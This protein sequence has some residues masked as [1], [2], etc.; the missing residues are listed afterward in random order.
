MGSS[1]RLSLRF[2]RFHRFC[3]ASRPNDVDDNCRK[4]ELEQSEARRSADVGMGRITLQCAPPVASAPAR[5]EELE[6][7][8]PFSNWATGWT[9]RSRRGTGAASPGCVVKIEARGVVLW[10]VDLFSRIFEVTGVRVAVVE[11]V[12]GDSVERQTFGLQVWSTRIGMIETPEYWRR[13]K[14]RIFWSLFV[15]VTVA[16]FSRRSLTLSVSGDV[17]SEMSLIGHAFSASRAIE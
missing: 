14:V 17:E 2:R 13:T 6:G 12:Q 1:R 3:T 9:G 5:N 4:V 11:E 15:K 7:V 16:R 10:V 8:V